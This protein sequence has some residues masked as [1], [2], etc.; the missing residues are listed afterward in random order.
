VPSGDAAAFADRICRL[1]ADPQRRRDMVLAA[2]R[3]LV[4]QY[5]SNRFADRLAE[6]YAGVPAA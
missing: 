1:V 5:S 6:L 2:R 3:R 4:E